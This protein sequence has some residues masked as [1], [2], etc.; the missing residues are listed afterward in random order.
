MAS[1]N[2]Q[3][4]GGYFS[5][6]DDMGVSF[7]GE[8]NLDKIPDGAFLS[9]EDADELLGIKDEDLFGDLDGGD[10]LDLDLDSD[11]EEFGDLSDFEDVDFDRIVA[12]AE[13]NQMELSSLFGDSGD[14]E[15][16]DI[17]IPEELN[18]DD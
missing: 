7:G 16:L 6:G 9:S 2:S 4:T 11:S 13:A 10:D 1:D 5:L 14:T 18:F 8:L 15:G 17:D 12:E 3:F